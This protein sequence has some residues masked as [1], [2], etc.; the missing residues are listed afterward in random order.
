MSTTKHVLFLTCSYQNLAYV[1]LFVGECEQNLRREN[2]RMEREK[3]W[4]SWE[5]EQIRYSQK[6]K[7][8]LP[9]LF[10]DQTISHEKNHIDVRDKIAVKITLSGFF[11]DITDLSDIFRIQFKFVFSFHQ[12]T[13]KPYQIGS[14][15]NCST[16]VWPELHRHFPCDLE[17]Q[18]VDAEDET[19][20]TYAWKARGSQFVGVLC[21][22]FVC[23]SLLV[24]SLFPFY[25]KFYT[26]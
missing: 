3:V 17:P 21:I 22:I 2:Q 5:C 14:Q 12:N 11:F 18:C 10:P 16:S 4:T 6:G 24:F 13:S 19:A 23:F 25:L 7:V 26:E 20:C 1:R 15:W 9:A 8:D